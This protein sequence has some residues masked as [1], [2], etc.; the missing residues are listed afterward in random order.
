MKGHV[1]NDP[2]DPH[3]TISPDALAPGD[4]SLD[5]T[6]MTFGPESL[7]QRLAPPGSVPRSPSASDSETDPAAA[8]AATGGPRYRLVRVVGE[9]GM[10][11]VYLALDGDLN[12]EVAL[13]TIREGKDHLLPQFIEEAQILGQLEHPNIVPIHEL[14][15]TPGDGR[16]YCT[17]R[18]VRGHTLADVLGRLRM[19]D[20]AVVAA[21]SLGRL[22]QI[23]IQITQAVGFAHD[24]GVA[25]CDLKPGNV[26]LGAHGEVQVLDW[27]LA[28]LIGR[29]APAGQGP[30]IAGTPGYMSPEQTTGAPATARSDVFTLGVILYELLTLSRPF[31]GAD[32]QAVI[33]A[34]RHDAPRPPREVAPDRP[35][36]L[37]LENTCL[38]AL[39]KDPGRR[40]GSA[41]AVAA[42]VQDWF[43]AETDR[44]KR[45]ALAEARALDGGA[46]LARYR[47]QLAENAR[48]EREAAEL[49]SAFKPWQPVEE[50][51]ALHA[52]EDRLAEGRA[53]L[54]QL[55]SDV[56]G[57][58]GEALAFEP[59][60]ATARGL[61]ADWYWDR[62]RE[63][64]AEGRHADRD[65]FGALVARYHDGK[66]ARE[67]LGEGTLTLVTD[68]PGAAAVLWELVED[69][70]RLVPSNPRPL[71]R[72]P[73]AA[74]PLSMGSYLVELTTPGRPA[75]RYPVFISRNRDWN[76]A[77]TLPAAAGVPDGFCFVPGGPFIQGGDDAT[78]GWCLPRAETWV[79]DVCIATHP[80]TMGEYLEFLNDLARTDMP[81][82]LKR[83]PR[84]LGTEAP[85]LR[86][87]ESGGL[88]MPDVD[89]EGDRW[90]ARMPAVMVSWHDA[91]AYCE[92][93]S[94]RDGRAYR[95]PSEA[96]WEKAA[97]GVDGRW[98]PWGNRFDASFCNLLESRQGRPSI[99]TVDEFPLDE[100]IYGVRGLAGNTQDWVGEIKQRGEGAR[101]RA[102]A[103][104]R[105]GHWA[106]QPVS[107]RCA[108]R[109]GLDPTSFHGFKSFRLATVP[110][111]PA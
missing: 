30:V 108:Y 111:R 70:L 68:P 50:K 84:M 98:Y 42:A 38:A 39:D 88:A 100:S 81:A 7:V 72:T 17:M 51:A 93:R 10:G 78:R 107:A 57:T 105:G 3:R 83:S 76:G 13:K 49:A 2:H 19:G 73:L 44:S 8:E 60:N 69:R 45:H 94:R 52:A 102:S 53:R 91:V 56:V 87:T 1:P 27:G 58:L 86:V 46:G 24:K 40:P 106:G 35:I 33:H 43:D 11:R 29:P 80:V 25:H 89:E 32:V 20:P 6:T 64:E 79:E 28:Q 92:W 61:L 90:D 62:F 47:R 110:G 85:L 36:P 22:V 34:T 12:R 59:E 21:Y 97:R 103:T 65:Y 55:A 23:F 37:A 41:H 5:D 74:V 63:A 77:V 14:A 4:G 67:L 31:T 54:A 109:E 104:L 66:Y 99:A 16:A 95:L 96:E 26:M 18:F 101:A 75:V 71:G 15:V 9:G 48:L 82:A